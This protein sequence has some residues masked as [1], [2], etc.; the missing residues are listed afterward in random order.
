MGR[1]TVY[2]H[3]YVPMDLL[4][5]MFMQGSLI[6]NMMQDH[7]GDEAFIRAVQRILELNNAKNVET[8]TLKAIE[9]TTGQNLDWFFK[10]WSMNQDIQNMMLNGLI[11]REIGPCKWL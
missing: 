8:K 5:D 2:D 6:L 1:P 9:E 7:L 4:M 3:Y 11:T 10:Q